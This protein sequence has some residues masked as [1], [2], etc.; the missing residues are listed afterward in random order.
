MDGFHFDA[1]ARTLAAGHSRRSV[2]RLLSGIALGGS[3]RLAEPVEAKKGKKKKKKKKHSCLT[4][5]GR[6][7]CPPGTICCTPSG[8]TTGGCA[9]PGY[10]VC[11]ASTPDYSWLPGTTC[12]SDPA[13]GI[14]GVCDDPSSPNCCSASTGSGCCPV[15]NSVCCLDETP[16]EAY[17]CPDASTCCPDTVSGCCDAGGTEITAASAVRVV[18]QSA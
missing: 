2:T 14:D 11:C 6:A 13:S 4:F 15:G 5:G 1:F 3:L 8:S 10:P 18:R 16:N 17:C 12:C 7:N 9:G